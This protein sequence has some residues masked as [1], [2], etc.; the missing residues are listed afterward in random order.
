MKILVTGGAGYIGS[1]MVKVLLD[2]GYEVVVADSL[3]KGFQEAVDSRAQCKNGNL[4][5]KSFVKELFSENA[6][7]GVIHFAAYISVA[8]SM[9]EPNKYFENNISG[10]LNVLEA[11][12]EHKVNNF[13]F[14]STAAV[15]G[16]PIK[17]P[18][19]ED[20]PKNPE[21]PYGESKLMVEKT[22]QWY[23]QLYNLNFIALR[24]FN[25]SGASLDASTGER[26]APETHI[27]PNVILAA[28]QNK[29]FTLFGDTYNTP[30]GTCIR[31]YI[32]V[33]DLCEAHVLALES[34]KNKGGT[35]SYNV[36]TGSGYSNK[37]I[38]EMVEK[39]SGK[40]IQTQ[41]AQKRAGDP[42]QLVADAGRIKE[43]LGFTPKYSDL[44]TIIKTAWDW[45][46]KNG[47]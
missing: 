22:L 25:A 14:S 40:S 45:H 8:E 5:E 46:N 44:E 42:D 27:I 12:R 37:Q 30:D 31:D 33:L 38:V 10:A 6:F 41:V 29:P 7:N 21:S 1:H 23:H 39:V 2:H 20:H 35:G 36:G 18:I 4:L 26:H 9:Q 3:E 17:V 15:Y 24:Y 32:H 13:I 34:L 11:M 43:D 47:R 19:D 16:T 28:I